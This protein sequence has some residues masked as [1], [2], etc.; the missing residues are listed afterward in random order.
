MAFQ[1]GSSTAA[2][3]HSP[4]NDEVELQN[5]L[6]EAIRQRDVHYEHIFVV[7]FTYESDDTNAKADSAAFA[8]GMK[9][10]FNLPD[11]NVFEGVL[12]ADWDA[13]GEF[14]IKVSVVEESLLDPGRR[15]PFGGADVGVILD[16]CSP[17]AS[18]TPTASDKT[19]EILAATDE[20]PITTLRKPAGVEATFTQRFISSLRSIVADE[21]KPPI[22]F[23]EILK[24]LQPRERE[25]SKPPPAY[26]MVYGDTPIHLP[27]PPQ[28]QL[29]SKPHLI[30]EAR[31]PQTHSL[32]LKLLLPAAVT[33]NSTRTV[34]KWL[35]NL[36]QSHGFELM[37]ANEHIDST[38]LFLTAPYTNL[39]ILHKLE[40]KGLCKIH[41]IHENLYSQNILNDIINPKD[42]ES[43]PGTGT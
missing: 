3:S 12:S 2:A 1:A 28:L 11:D 20:I 5:K 37:G 24:N 35:H 32:S 10:I 14:S 21:R 43:A 34:I 38:L 30:S 41:V 36:Q 8:W 7:T 6:N 23:P 15:T 22:I 33:D 42:S 18:V 27:V 26:W 17:G 4:T 40:H 9:D 25:S 16:C 31:V 29:A 19:V 39:H 13:E